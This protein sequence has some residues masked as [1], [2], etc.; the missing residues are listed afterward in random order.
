MLDRWQDE[1]AGNPRDQEY[2]ASGGEQS[3][4]PT[5]PELTQGNATVLADF[6]NNEAGDQESREHEEHVHADEST[7]N[8]RRPGVIQ[9]DDREGQSTHALNVGAETMAD[10]NG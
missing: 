9:D 10:L 2:K 7:G 5:A 4:G 6:A 3:S 8:E 1:K